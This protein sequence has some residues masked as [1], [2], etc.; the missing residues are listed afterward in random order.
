MYVRYLYFEIKRAFGVLLSSLLYLVIA[1]GLLALLVFFL[2][3]AA[4]SRQELRLFN[5]SLYVPEEDSYTRLAT[6]LAADMESFKSLCVFNY[7]ESEEAVRREVESGNSLAGIVFPKDFANSVYA[8]SPTA[9]KLFYPEDMKD[10]EMLFGEIIR[11]FLDILR[12]SE[13]GISVMWD[14][15]KKYPVT[16]NRE[17]AGSPGI[18]GMA[19]DG[20]NV[21]DY[22]ALLY[23]DIIFKRNRMYDPVVISPFGDMDAETFYI[24]IGIF[25]LLIMYGVNFSGLYGKHTAALT[26]C[27]NIAGVRALPR[28]I[29]RVIAISLVLLTI[30]AAI[31]IML[32]I[33]GVGYITYELLYFIPLIPALGL[34]F[35]GIMLI[36]GG[37]PQGSINVFIVNIVIIAILLLMI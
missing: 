16:V 34:Y 33:A 28:G 27:M 22:T 29:A 35:H 36:S 5:V 2:T 4:H 8:G 10:S 17:A 21:G 20:F 23:A 25:T 14:L 3:G 15:S 9:M 1:V 19:T 31:F 13:A 32:S 37:G 18:F 11:N 6:R 24:G 7:E 12:V 30:T 26:D